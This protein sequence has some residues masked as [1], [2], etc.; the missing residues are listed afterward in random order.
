M[1]TPEEGESEPEW[2]T[3]ER[4]HFSEYR[5]MNKVRNKKITFTTKC[6][7]DVRGVAS[8]PASICG[9]VA[10]G[11]VGPGGGGVASVHVNEFS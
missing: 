8:V 2:V 3:T 7:I 1:F 10:S 11:P 5:D 9:G 4:K 6:L